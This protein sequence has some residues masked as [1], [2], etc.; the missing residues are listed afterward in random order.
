[1]APRAQRHHATSGSELRRVE[2]RDDPLGPEELRYCVTVIFTVSGWDAAVDPV[3]A[4]AVTLT[5]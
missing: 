1:M 4:D 5:E 3:P 2:R